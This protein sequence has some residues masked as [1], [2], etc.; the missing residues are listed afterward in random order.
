MSRY[1]FRPKQWPDH[2]ALALGWD[3]GL[4]TYYAQVMDYSIGQDDDC[5]IVWIAPTLGGITDLTT[6]MRTLHVR[7]DGRLPR[8]RLSPT[9]RC[10]LL[11][12]KLVTPQR[13]EEDDSDDGSFIPF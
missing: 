1:E 12:D 3:P 13:F 10:R 2:T 4:D 11:K 7:L 9:R 5:V 8:V 6:L